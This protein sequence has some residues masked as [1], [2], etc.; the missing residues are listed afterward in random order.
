LDPYRYIAD[1]VYEADDFY[2]VSQNIALGCWKCAYM[3]D[4]ITMYELLGCLL[5]VE[6][7][8]FP[9]TSKHWKPRGPRKKEDREAHGYG[10]STKVIMYSAS[11]HFGD[12]KSRQAEQLRKD[13]GVPW[14][15]FEDFVKMLDKELKSRR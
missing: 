9:C 6:E 3:G 4:V 8:P 2:E 11:R 12:A 15:V 7:Y 5:D 10:T 14:Q 13:Y 1:I